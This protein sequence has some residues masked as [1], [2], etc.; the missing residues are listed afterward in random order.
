MF[1]MGPG[2]QQRPGVLRLRDG[3]PWR[4]VDGA[5][6]VLDLETN[7]YFSV[8]QTGARLWPNL[9]AGA[10][11]EELIGVLAEAEQLTPERARADVEAFVGNLRADALLA[12]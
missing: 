9:H 1:A 8:N 7:S 2:G 4:E 10:T 3:L 5:I 12:P 6:V 11:L